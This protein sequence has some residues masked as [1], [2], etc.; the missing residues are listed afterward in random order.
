MEIK[1]FLAERGLYAESDY[2]SGS[3]SIKETETRNTV[4]TLA[5]TDLSIMKTKNEITK[6]IESKLK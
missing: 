5:G 6:L 4:A 2:D 1:D 3:V